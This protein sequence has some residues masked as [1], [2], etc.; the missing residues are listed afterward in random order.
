MTL[1]KLET[2]H[3]TVFYTDLPYCDRS[4]TSEVHRQRRQHLLHL[5]LH[6]FSL[7]LP[8][9]FLFFTESAPRPRQRDLFTMAREEL[10][11]SAVGYPIPL[12]A[13]NGY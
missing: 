5:H 10:I 2:V 4:A 3:N 11:S 12:S 1:G 9:A 6:L 8:L 13:W 7:S